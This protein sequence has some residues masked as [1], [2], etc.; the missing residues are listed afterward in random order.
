MGNK[1][2][3]MCGKMA[4]GKSTLSKV[5]AKEHNA[6]LLSEDEILGKLYPNKIESL[7]D[8]V[9]YS[10]MV[11]ELFKEHIIE[12]LKKGCNVVLDFPANT[13]SQR[14]WFKEIYVEAWVSHEL[15]FVDKSDKT[16]K[17]QLQ[18]RNKDLPDDA[19][20]SSEESFDMI[21]KYFQVPEDNEGFEIKRYE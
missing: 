15:H 2:H 18:I 20:F 17:E 16:C 4:S 13:K 7:E 19:P 12:L 6:I 21:T 3:F 9:K 8:Y 1:L 11:K 10:S 14:E 5:L